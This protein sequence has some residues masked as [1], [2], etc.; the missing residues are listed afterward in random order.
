MTEQHVT[1][2]LAFMERHMAYLPVRKD[3]S[4]AAKHPAKV[5]LYLNEA[6][7]DASVVVAGIL[8]DILEDTPVTFSQIEIAF[9][10]ETAALVQVL[11][12]DTRKSGKKQ[13]RDHLTRIEANGK[14]AIAIKLADN[15]NNL[16][17]IEYMNP[18]NQDA[19]LRYAK[20][21][22]QLGE[23]YL[24]ESHTLVS[25]HSRTLYAARLRIQS[26]I[27]THV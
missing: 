11:T 26:P 8:H 3:G 2:A 22:L 15:A 14:D 4:P 7:M 1:Q 5:G 10:R 25:L 13:E 20:K 16:E 27:P 9:N 24:G 17:T 21:I 19:Y 23:T 18:K 12:K 6:G